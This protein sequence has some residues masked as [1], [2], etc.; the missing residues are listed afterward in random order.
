VILCIALGLEFTMYLFGHLDS[1]TFVTVVIL[2]PSA[3]KVGLVT[4]GYF[5]STEPTLCWRHWEHQAI[6]F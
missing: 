3:K 2:V 6:R 4:G 5:N 1:S